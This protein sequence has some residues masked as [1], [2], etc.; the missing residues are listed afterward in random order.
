MLRRLFIGKVKFKYIAGYT[1]ILIFCA[2]IF[3]MVGGG[4][5]KTLINRVTLWYSGTVEGVPDDYAR[6]VVLLN[7]SSKDSIKESAENNQT[8]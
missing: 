2:I 1:G 4:R 6:Q 5:T 8:K 3:V 7:K